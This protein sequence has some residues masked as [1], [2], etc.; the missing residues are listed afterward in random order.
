MRLRFT[1]R[2]LDQLEAI[3]TYLAERNPAA[4]RRVMAEIHGAA[5][6]L[7]R[8]PFMARPGRVLATREWVIRGTPYILVY[9]VDEVAAEIVVMAVFHGAQD[10]NEERGT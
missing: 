5:G 2:A 4:A 9:E 8:Y 10:R 7:L 6:R 3:R 1:A